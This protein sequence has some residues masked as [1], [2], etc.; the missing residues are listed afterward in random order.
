MDTAPRAGQNNTRA[1]SSTW[2]FFCLATLL[3]LAPLLR[4]GNRQLAIGLLL[5]LGLCILASLITQLITRRPWQPANL[6]VQ[7]RLQTAAILLLASSPIW[8]AAIQLTPFDPTLWSSLAGRGDYLSALAK[9]GQTPPDSLPLSLNPGATRAALWSALPASAA[10]AAAFLIDRRQTDRLLSIV[11]AAAAVQTLIAVLQLG[12]GKTSLFYFGSDHAGSVIGTFNN[13]N[14]LADF[15]GMSVPLWFY[16]AL[17]GNHKHRTGAARLI[18]R[19]AWWP[20]WVTFGFAMLVVLLLTQSRGGLLSTSIALAT[21]GWLMLRAP[22]SDSGPQLT[23]RLR[24]ATVAALGLTIGAALI[25]VGLENLAN[26]VQTDRLVV[27]ANVRGDYSLDTLQAAKHFWPWGSGAGTFESVFPRFQSLQ[28]FGYVEYAHND[29]PQLLME[30]GA[31]A[32]PLIAAAL[33][34]AAK[35]LRQLR[36]NA[37]TRQS[38]R[39]HVLQ[40]QLAGL[41][42]LILLL[43]SWVEF[44][45]HI[46]ALAITAAF[47]AGVYLRPIPASSSEDE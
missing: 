46:P 18:P 15:L 37:S 34:L 42:V 3:T 29:Y 22:A 21:C 9:L 8:L 13:R 26:R 11:L 45:M 32:L 14:H 47:L 6:P 39:N 30:L 20:L 24:W 44:N 27:D 7:N 40:R 2:V 4:G 35:Q 23:P 31:L 5:A 10:F 25:S 41:S 43:H 12:G 36:R 17:R 38:T 16:F 33:Y 19:N 1:D 28:T